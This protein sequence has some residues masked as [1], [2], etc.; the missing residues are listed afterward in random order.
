MMQGRQLG[1]L[2]MVSVVA[3]NL[4]ACVTTRRVELS[5]GG[6][7]PATI[8]IGDRVSV[9]DAAGSTTDLAVTVVES[10]FLEG[11]ADDGRPV[12]F[13]VADIRELRERDRAPGK[14]VA[15]GV[16]IGIGLFVHALSRWGTVTW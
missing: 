2:I 6:T 14:S 8:E 12:R 13:A 4:T 1:S 16:G 11:T 15:L 9:V 5:N 10:G 7:L 3:F